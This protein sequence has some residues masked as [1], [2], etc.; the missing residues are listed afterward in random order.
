VVASTPR[1]P[2]RL[3][4][5]RAAPRPAFEQYQ[6]QHEAEQEC[7]QLGGRHR[8]AEAE[9]GP[10]DARGEGVDA[11]VLHR[12]EVVQR[13]HQRQCGAAG[14][15][16]AGQWQGDAAEQSPRPAA[17]GPADL[18][19]ADRLVEKRGAGDQVDVGIQDQR[20]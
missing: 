12:P 16:R 1:R 18:E 17:E 11:E 9:P 13:F 20:Q 15:R 8:F 6:E 10:V 3:E 2:G 5:L 14:Y 4:E 7:G 19:R